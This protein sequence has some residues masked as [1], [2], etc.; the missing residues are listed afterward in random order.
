VRVR[1][2]DRAGALAALDA[3][4]DTSSE[5]VAAQLAAVE[6]VLS[7]RFGTDPGEEELRAAAARV[8]GLRLDAATAQRVRTRLFEEAVELAPNGAGGAPLL[9]CPWNERSLRLA[10]EA[11]LRASA[12][13][14]SDPG[15]RM[16]LVD[17]AN[18]VRPRTWV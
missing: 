14:A 16:V 18:A 13:L 5:Y 8:E 9:Q 7:D 6:V 10:L 12:R 3:V 15:E 17:R 1:A 4:P 11:S 2:G